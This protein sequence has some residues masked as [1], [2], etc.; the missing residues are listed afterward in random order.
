MADG[1]II[2]DNNKIGFNGWIILTTFG[3]ILGALILSFIWRVIKN[4]LNV[5][6]KDSI[7][8]MQNVRQYVFYNYGREGGE[9]ENDYDEISVISESKFE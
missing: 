7:D 9:Y 8:S 6:R 2:F 4:K 5:K 3:V 1:N